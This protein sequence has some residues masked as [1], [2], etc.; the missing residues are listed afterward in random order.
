MQ[1]IMSVILS[2]LL[3]GNKLDLSKDR[4]VT[5]EEA[6]EVAQELGLRYIETSAKDNI[7]VSECFE[8]LV[9][10]IE[11]KYHSDQKSN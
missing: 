1:W 4:V 5:T 10:E 8:F 3:V 11:K 9:E 6:N 2:I 7:N